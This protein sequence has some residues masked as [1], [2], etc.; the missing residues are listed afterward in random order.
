MSEV[1]VRPAASI[2]AIHWFLALSLAVLAGGAVAAPRVAVAKYVK[3]EV[4]MEIP[5]L[6]DAE[7]AGKPLGQSDIVESGSRIAA[8]QDG[9]AV[10]RLL[11]DHAF[12]EVRP[13]TSFKLRRVKS[14]GKRIRRVH[15]DLGEVV[16]GLRKKSEQVQCMTAHSTATADKARF[17]CRAEDLSALGPNRDASGG[18]V[19]VVVVQ[20]GE[21]TVYN[22]PKNLSAVARSGQK[23]VS[24]LNG[25]RITDATDAELEQV[26][27]RQNTLEVDFLNP[28]TDEFTTLEIEYETGF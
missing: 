8:G 2:H 12:L 11:P 9:K 27:F 17:S 18:S 10:I 16:F 3:G 20:D 28:Q 24:D 22:R 15:L 26:G 6:A 13:K 25:I 5:P 14:K 4:R 19:A 7:E 1:P 23:A 21:V